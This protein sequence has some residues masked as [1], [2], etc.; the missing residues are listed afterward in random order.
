MKYHLFFN[1]CIY[2]ILNY[3][4]TW[5]ISIDIW[6]EFENDFFTFFKTE[7]EK[8]N[9][10]IKYYNSNT[11][12]SDGLTFQY[13]LKKGQENPN[14]DQ[15]EN[16]LHIEVFDSKINYNDL[17]PVLKNKIIYLINN[18]ERRAKEPTLHI[19][20]TIKFSQNNPYFGYFIQGLN[21]NRI[22]NFNVDF[23]IEKKKDAGY[24]KI[25]KDS[26]YVSSN[27]SIKILEIAE[28]I[29]ILSASGGS[30]A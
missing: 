12:G 23:N 13:Y 27:S 19:Q 17:I 16:Q 5:N 14:N 25:T 4:F 8:I 21:F 11:F 28:N 29:M 18:I 20:L 6:A 7:I 22:N 10:N 24:V 15:C 3:G 9:K 1:H 30:V 26:I 2:T